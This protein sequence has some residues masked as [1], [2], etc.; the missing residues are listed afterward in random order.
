MPTPSP[1][2]GR[3]RILT[4][5]AIDA[6]LLVG[7]HAGALLLAAAWLLARTGVGRLD[8]GSGDAAVAVALA[9]SAAPAWIAWTL[10]ATHR[11]LSTPGQR[12]GG[13][14]PVP[15]G[16]APRG[17]LYLRAMVTPLSLPGWLWMAATP[18]LAG[19]PGWLALPPL[20]AAM[21]V[22]AGGIGSLGLV[23]VRPSA[24][25]VHDRVAR[26]A[27]VMVES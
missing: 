10:L 27:L 12:V 13:I 1:E 6:G 16:R 4:A 21:G 11:G 17:A 23:L 24:R 25:L 9:G 26:T 8:V 2:P 22:A 7:I 15:A 14:R 5:A 3:A 18:L 20:L 19:M